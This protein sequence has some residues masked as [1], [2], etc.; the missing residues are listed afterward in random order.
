MSYQLTSQLQNILDKSLHPQK[1][2]GLVVKIE[3]GDGSFS[4]QGSAGNLDTGSFYFIASTSKLYIT[5][6][7]L[8]L[9]QEG[10]L[11][12]E[13]TL[14]DYLSSDL[15]AG[16][17]V[18]K[19]VDYSDS[20]TIKQLLAHTSGVPDY[21]ED[22]PAKGDKLINTLLKGED[23]YWGFE[24]VIDRVRTMKPFFKPGTPGKAHY[25]D[26][27]FQLLDQVIETITGEKI[28]RALQEYIFHPLKL[29]N[30]YLYQDIQDTNPPEIYYKQGKLHIPRAMTSFRGDG[31]IVSTA[32]ESMIFLK[33]FFNGTFFP[34][35]Y[36]ED[37]KKWNKIFFPL[38]YGVGL[39]RFK[40][41][42]I[43]SPL[44]AVPEFW[45]HSG[46]SGAFSYYCPV[47]DLYFT[48]TVNQAAYPNLSYK[49]LIK[50]VNSF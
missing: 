45:G 9:R 8:Q 46:L 50:L 42:R 15:I 20:I 1:I 19:G 40:L 32:S 12:L 18:F 5:A 22:K 39:M 13:D 44:K 30:T 6:L 29:K 49:L 41:P 37:L 43:F 11:D 33:A 38:Q 4:W 31:G 24:D 27:N 7:I 10:K 17:H 21:F 47:K 36:L 16:I 25:S 23:E 2:P 26:T 35:D 14:A 28:A 3:S 48:G 34:V